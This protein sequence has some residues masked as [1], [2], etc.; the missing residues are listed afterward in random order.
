MTISNIISSL[1]LFF[2]GFFYFLKRR[3]LVP[4]ALLP[5]GLTQGTVF[6]TLSVYTNDILPPQLFFIS[7]LVNRVHSLLMGFLNEFFVKV[8]ES[9]DKDLGVKLMIMALFGILSAI[10]LVRGVMVESSGKERSWN[11]AEIMSY[12]GYFNGFKE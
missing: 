10:F 11:Q 8:E 12:D 2:I 9:H 7:F 3:D 5:I 1:C 6:A 4:L